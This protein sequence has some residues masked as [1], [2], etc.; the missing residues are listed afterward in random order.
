LGNLKD[1]KTLVMIS[2]LA[3][4]TQ[5]PKLPEKK[6]AIIYFINLGGNLLIFVDEEVYRVILD[7]YGVNDIT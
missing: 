1:V 5:K 3:R 6:I 7:E 2:P 4:P